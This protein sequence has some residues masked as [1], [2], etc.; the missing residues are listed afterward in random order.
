MDNMVFQH[1]ALKKKKK[2]SYELQSS[3]YVHC[4]TLYLIKI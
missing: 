3:I 2:R 4:F 1:C